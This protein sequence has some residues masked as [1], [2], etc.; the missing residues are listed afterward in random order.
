MFENMENLKIL[1][2]LHKKNKDY[3]EIE[4][5][6]INSFF[7]R[8]GGSVLCDFYNKKIL[9][10][11]GEILFIPKGTSYSVKALSQGTT[12]ISI[13]F[14][15]D[16]K[17]TPYPASFS[18]DDFPEAEYIISSFY[19]MWNFGG[20]AER[21]QCNSLFFS[22]LSYLCKLENK[23]ELKDEKL[24]LIE[25]AISYIRKSIYSTSLK[26]EKLHHLCGISDTYFRRLF[27]LE[28]GKT[29]QNYIAS[30]RMSHA[31]A[32]IS[33]GDFNSI[34]EVALSVGYN[35]PLYFSKVFKKIYGISPSKFNKN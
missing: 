34:E 4:N 31:R 12:Y 20:P 8:S 11:E 18:L 35:D 21:Y 23:E 26:V 2:S 33:S 29:P 17:D 13:N 19:D 5:R 3:V 9:V 27:T 10:K 25:P 6:K 14:E 24:K 22:L 32:I 7:I 28:F 30:K 1:Y 15:A 16:F